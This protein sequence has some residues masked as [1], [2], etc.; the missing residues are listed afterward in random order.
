MKKIIL[1]I[2]FLTILIATVMAIQNAYEKIITS[3]TELSNK[4]DIVIAGNKD[5]NEKLD[6]P[7]ELINE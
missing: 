3:N 2:V 7:L 1:Y 5:I 4:L 6:Q